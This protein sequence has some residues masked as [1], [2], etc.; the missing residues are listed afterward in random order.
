MFTICSKNGIMSKE[1]R[2]KKLIFIVFERTFVLLVCYIIPHEFHNLDSQYLYRGVT[3]DLKFSN[4]DD[5]IVLMGFRRLTKFSFKEC[6][7][8]T[9]AHRKISNYVNMCHQVHQKQ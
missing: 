1:S 4:R 3:V 7:T 5:P 8:Q 6:G 2:L 9:K